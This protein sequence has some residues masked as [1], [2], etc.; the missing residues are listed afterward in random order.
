MKLKIITRLFI[1]SVLTSVSVFSQDL[2]V[3]G[4]VSDFQNNPI[5]YANI[6]L[7]T[8][9]DS[10]VIKGASSNEQGFFLI[11]QVTPGSYLLKTSFIGFK[12]NT[13]NLEITDSSLDLGDIILEESAE[14]L[15]EVS[16]VV[17]KPTLTKEA[18]RLV[19]NVAN[20]ALSEGNLMEVLKSTP[21][22]L[23]LDGKLSVRNA[24]PTV[25]INDRKVQL[26]GSELMNLL[27]GSPASSIKSIEVITNPSAK[28]D[29]SDG[30]IVNIVMSKNLVAGYRGS[31]FANY[32]QGVYPRYNAGI[33]NFYKTD[34]IN[35][36]ASYSYNNDKTARVSDEN[37]NFINDDG[38][39]Y[40]QWFSNFDRTTK[41]QTHTINTNFDYFINDNNT[42][43][44]SANLLFLPEF[45]YVIN[46]QTDVFDPA[47]NLLYNFDNVNN[48]NDDK[49]NLGFDLDY[50]SRFNNGSKL[51]FNAHLT[52]Y[53]YNRDQSV[54]SNYFFSDSS[55]NFSNA[56]ETVSKQNT[57]IT[58]AQA[59]Y[60]LPFSDSASVSLGIKG[61]FVN[62]DSEI[63]QFVL[64]EGNPIFDPT[65][66]NAFDYNEDVLAV[67]AD[68]EKS[69]EKWDLNIGLRV[70][71]SNIEG[72]SLVT[73][74]TLT[75]DY[76]NW[77]P[78]ANL[79]FQASEKIGIYSNYK[80]SIQRPDYQSLN[81]F[82][83]YL[84]DNTIVTGNPNLQPALTDH[85]VIGTSLNNSFFLEAYYKDT[86]SNFVELPL[87]DN[88]NN[89]LIY[90]PT[91]IASTIDYGFDFL[92]YFDITSR[93]NVYFGT[94]FYNIEEQTTIN[95]SLL[96]KNTWSNYT[97]LNNSLSFLEDNTL[98][99]N[100]SLI[101]YG[102]NQQGFQIVDS[103]FLSELT[104]KKMLWD[105]KWA[106]SLVVAD[107]FNQQD[108]TVTSKY[109][110]Q[111]NS[112]F[113]D[114]DNRYIKL[115]ISYKFGN[116][117][118]ETNQRTKDR[119]E[120]DRLERK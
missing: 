104:I 61:S 106:L 105:N 11:E 33:T 70:E 41:S 28:Y 66:S 40:E 53:D 72:L 93:W 94:S 110:N 96:E 117:G 51:S 89:L 109:L 62:T 91:N 108:Y 77:F 1:L 83:F 74:N 68:Y 5:S 4:F 100:L 48:S 59:D 78:T 90:T 26:S 54:Y 65:N 22:V 24:T 87:Q 98:S 71:Q 60:S 6:V 42:L 46:G 9:N 92:A 25:Y 81:P 44:F 39:I 56:F 36:F 31:V 88:V 10:T 99:A 16:I 12:S 116:S 102:K 20:T 35:V 114:Q 3:S 80:R 15:N 118:L 45:N 58:T 95:G 69:W 63:N 113:L 2:S 37:V 50:V 119:D 34:K 112:R 27:E 29:A 8:V 85:F 84:N 97:E 103:R 30:V 111:D 43:S 49:Y 67:Y 73:N 7:L 76:L 57:L 32:T 75:Q 14:A 107:I 82:R 64:Q 38:A 101:F 115:G 79:S 19:F 17:N 55:L 18:D 21:S 47:L 52:T 13:L 120:R 86:E 23:V